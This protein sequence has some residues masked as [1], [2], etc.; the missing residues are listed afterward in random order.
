MPQVRTLRRGGP[1]ED[2]Q[3]FLEAI[4]RIMVVERQSDGAQRAVK[5]TLA[6]EAA[7][8]RRLYAFSECARNLEAAADALMHAGLRLRD[9][10]LGEMVAE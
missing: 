6:R 9:H 1:R 3:D 5:Q 4:H 8:Y 7:D 10:V 2:M